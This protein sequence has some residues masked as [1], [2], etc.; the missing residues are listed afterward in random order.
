MSG[1]KVSKV[2]AVCPVFLEFNGYERVRDYLL[3]CSRLI[4]FG[5]RKD[6]AYK[7]GGT[8][9]EA[10]LRV[11]LGNRYL[12]PDTEVL[13]EP[14][15]QVLDTLKEWVFD[16]RQVSRKTQSVLVSNIDFHI[17]RRRFFTTESGLIG[18]GPSNMTPG[19][20]VWIL[21]GG[22]MN[23]EAVVNGVEKRIWLN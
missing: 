9:R 21:F 2:A 5:F 15:A 18:F 16:L 22:I 20:E 8:L 13:Q 19:D 12:N 4:D 7:A 6:S 10:F 23:G 17:L 14:E 3:Q 11:I 1:F